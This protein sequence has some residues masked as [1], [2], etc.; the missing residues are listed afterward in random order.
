MKC[1]HCTVSY[2]S[3][4]QSV[5]IG[6]DKDKD[7]YIIRDYCPECQRHNLRLNNSAAKRV[8]YLIYPKGVARVPLPASV[9]ERYSKE[10]LEACVVLPDSAKASAA[11]S[12]RCLQIMIR[13]ELKIQKKDLFQEIDEVLRQNKLP[14]YLSE[15][16]D[17]IRNIGNFA[18]HPI[19]STNTGEI[20]EVEPGEAEWLLDLLEGLFDFLFV[21][22]EII[23]K[24]KEALNQK[25]K[26]AGKPEML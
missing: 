21:Q 5:Y 13:E 25:L 14:S 24:K 3:N 1:P 20:V 17:A 16:I 9:P 12:R 4:P 10:Y 22:P 7:W 8:E 19:K 2:N 26:D 6:K 23:K 18:A 11:I 15:G